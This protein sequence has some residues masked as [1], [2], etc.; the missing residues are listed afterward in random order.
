MNRSL[1]HVEI[2][3]STWDT[4]RDYF[5]Q[6]TD[7]DK[8]QARMESTLEGG[9]VAEHHKIREALIA[10]RETLDAMWGRDEVKL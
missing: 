10:H 4:S 2:F 1:A 9:S 5:V 7:L 3:P 6:L 8:E